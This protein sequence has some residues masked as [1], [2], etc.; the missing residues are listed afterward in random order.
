[1]KVAFLSYGFGMEVSGS[2]KYGFYLVKELQKLGVTIDVFNAKFIFKTFGAPMFYLKNAFLRLNDYDIVH[3]NEGSGIFLRH[4]CMIDTWH[5]DYRQSYDVNGLI[6]QNLEMLQ[7]LKVRHIIVPSYATKNALLRYGFRED[8]ITVIYHGVDHTIFKKK[9]SSV[10]LRKKYGLSNDFVIINVGKLIKRKRQ[11]DIINALAGIY[12][13]AL[14]LVGEGKEE[15]N[16]KRIAKEKQVKLIHFRRVP[17]SFLVD[18]YN[19]ADVYVHTSVLEGFGLTILEAMACGLPIVAYK[20]ADFTKIVQEAGV[21]LKLCDVRGI[22]DAL[23]YLKENMAEREKLGQIAQKESAKYTW[24]KTA[25]E[26]LNVYLR[27]INE[28]Q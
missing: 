14:I 21:L 26:H 23:F 16:I 13:T 15:S 20:V 17:E 8:K 11:I 12:D 4:P 1:M 22:R 6:F 18:L 5:H 9:N 3:S 10:L 2:G 28:S 24:E 27:V 19:I 25:K 7:G